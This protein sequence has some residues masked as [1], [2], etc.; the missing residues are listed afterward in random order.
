MGDFTTEAVQVGETEL[1][2]LKG[3]SGPPCLV[4]HGFEGHE[5]WLAF[6]EALAEHA[7]V[8]APSH[9]GYGHTTAPEWLRTISHQAVFYNWFLQ[10]TGLESADVV[11]TGV[12]GWIAAEMA[13][14]CTT[15]MRKLVLID[16]AGIRPEQGE[17]FDIFVTPWRSVIE[18]GFLNSVG[19]PEYQRIY[20]EAPIQEF[21][22][23]REAGRTMS[24]KMCFK[25]YMY[26]AALP[27]MLGKVRA[28]TLIVWGRED[29]IV[30]LECA[31]LFERALPDATVRVIEQCGHFAHLEQ[32]T[33]VAHLI[34]EFVTA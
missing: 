31:Y 28:P 20:G 29:Q 19:A 5:G 4:L 32:P 16:S 6:H 11:G 9:Q 10:A 15:R 12:G 33:E 30:P 13:L 22:G 8:Y 23:I 7:T 25:P 3:G 21:G 18:R 27:A 24:M 1:F 17:I 14:Q 26:D 34:S 2:V